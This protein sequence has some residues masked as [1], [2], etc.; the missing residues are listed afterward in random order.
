MPL[1]IIDSALS[2]TVS[3][4]NFFFRARYSMVLM[5]LSAARSRLNCG[6]TVLLSVVDFLC[7]GRR[8]ACQMAGFSASALGDNTSLLTAESVFKSRH[9]MILCH[10]F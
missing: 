8:I 9:P 1:N 2:E 4:S 3:M 5:V 7:N 10:F 6:C